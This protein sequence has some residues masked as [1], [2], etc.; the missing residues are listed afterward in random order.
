MK[1]T[2][3]ENKK[4]GYVVFVVNEITTDQSRELGNRVVDRY[5]KL[6]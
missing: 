4:N 5:I 1:E 2:E 3:E 6:V